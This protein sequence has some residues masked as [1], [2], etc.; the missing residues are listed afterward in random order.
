MSHL[1]RMDQFV[2]TFG[3]VD[4][5]RAAITVLVAALSGFLLL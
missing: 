3:A 4:G 2:T 5:F 1:S